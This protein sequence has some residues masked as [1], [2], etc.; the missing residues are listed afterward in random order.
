M[1]K[2]FRPLVAA[3]SLFALIA[4][5]AQAE[6]V[7][8]FLSRAN[9]TALVLRGAVSY[10]RSIVDIHYDSLEANPVEGQVVLR[11]LRIAGWGPWEGCKISLGKMDMS[12][13]AMFLPEDGSGRLDLVDLKIANGCFGANAPMVGMVTGG[14]EISISNLS[15]DMT[16][17][18]GSGAVK[19]NFVVASPGI[20]NIEG[21]ADF[22]YVTVYYPGIVREIMGGDPFAAPSGSP[23][24]D[25]SM[26]QPEVGLRGTL[27]S[28]HLTVED[29]GAWTRMNVMLPPEALGPEGLQGLITAAPGT[30]LH[31]VQQEFVAS[32]QKFI[33]NP[34]RL[35]AE[36]RPETPIQFASAEWKGPDDAAALL[37][38]RFSNALPSPSVAL[39]AD[40][41]DDSDARALG[42]AFARGE[43]VPQNTQ[44]AIALLKPLAEDGEIA[45]ELADLT[46]PNDPAAAY[47]YAM[48]AAKAGA[49][50]APAAIDRIEARLS[51]ADVLKAQPAADSDLAEADYQSI[52]AL[53]QAALD[54]EN[55]QGRERS[56]AVA[57]RLA[58][59]AAA[60]GDIISQALLQRLDSR[61]GDDA[62]WQEARTEAS[63]AALA[64]WDRLSLAQ[65]FS[66]Q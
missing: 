18:V 66:G 1:I 53:R 56:Y 64:D 2:S 51:V 24:Q 19:A 21:S 34:G 26:A 10:G 12:G 15:V 54:Y 45:L 55:G 65:K 9:L 59:L 44:R 27:R 13:G 6:D 16:S 28:A 57:W 31:G 22:D 41:S 20:A 46:L 61:F 48:Q 35:T 3:T 42:I 37:K 36:I 40:P 50:G 52:P 11:N 5:S 33:E 62:D 17:T 23:M 25:Q 7:G 39:I 30:A 43:G 4:G 63:D 14:S 60:S 32:L 58:S 38:P 47:V 8:S 49:V 29:Q